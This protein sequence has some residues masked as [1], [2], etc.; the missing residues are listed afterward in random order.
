MSKRVSDMILAACVLS[1]RMTQDQ[2]LEI[3]AKL[4]EPEAEKQLFDSIA[5]LLLKLK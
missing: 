2:A 4:D 5:E 1:E 3:Q